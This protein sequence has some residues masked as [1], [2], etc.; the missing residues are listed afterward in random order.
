MENFTIP[1]GLEIKEYNGEGY[2]RTHIFGAWCVAFLNHA[3]RFD[4]VTYLERHLLTDEIFVLL[5]GE[6]ELLIGEKGEPVKLEPCKLFNVKA[7]VWHAV[8]ASRDAKLLIVEN[9][10]TVKENSEYMDFIPQ[11]S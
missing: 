3:E 1:N 8:R 4:R 6:A 5:S 9:S 11:E 7:G 10:D 2:D